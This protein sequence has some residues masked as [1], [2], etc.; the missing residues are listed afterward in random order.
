MPTENLYDTLRERGFLKQCSDEPAV[1]ELLAGPPAHVYVGFDPTAPSLHAGSLVPIMALVHVQRSGHVP[2]ALVGGGTGL[3]GDPSGKIE[4]RQLLSRE[5]LRV[6]FAGIRAQLGRFLDFD[7]DRAVAVDNAQWLEPLNYLDFLRE[8]GRH[9]SVNKMLSYEAYRL[10]M[11]KGLSFLEFN[12]Q[13]L[14]AYDYLVLFRQHGCRLQMGGDDQWGNILAGTDLIR[15]VEGAE[16]HALTFPLLTCASGAKMGKTATGAVWLD[17]AQTS[18][19]D[20]Y[21]YWV[22]VDD[23]DVGRFLGLFTLLPM[24]EV[25]GFAA[26]EGAE[27]REAKAKLAFEATTIL[28]GPAEAER[29]RQGAGAA[30]GGEGS[31]DDM[32]TFALQ[33]AR[34]VEGLRA[35]DLFAEAGLCQSKGEATKLFRSGGGRVGERVLQG[36]TDTMGEADF[37]GGA[38]VLRAGRKRIVRVLLV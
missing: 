2:V 34:L 30:F 23:R 10:R 7:G 22:N 35:V 12:Y 19:Y 26:L 21:Q 20:Y 4:Q 17:A 25:R 5:T 13:L 37:P 3:I 11:E 8:I 38:A 29:A 15:R 14:Q 24:D 9:F 33:R 6:N 32:P 31:V 27:L 28:H 16:A 18:P 1:R 36:H